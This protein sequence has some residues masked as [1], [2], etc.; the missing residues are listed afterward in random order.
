MYSHRTDLAALGRALRGV[1]D[2]TDADFAAMPF[3]VRP[4]V[5]RGFGKASGRSLAEWRRLGDQLAQAGGGALP[6]G[7]L[8]AALE[9]L[10]AVFRETPGHAR[11]SFAGADWLENLALRCGEREAVLRG[12]I[13]GLEG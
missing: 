2:E 10:A 11:K 3:L 7:E 12:L 5:R 8:R 6:A 1:I 4:F 13:A 9:Q